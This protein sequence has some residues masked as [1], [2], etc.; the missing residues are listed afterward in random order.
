MKKLGI[1]VGLLLGM[2]TVASAGVTFTCPSNEQINKGEL[3][4]SKSMKIY[5]V[6]AN[7]LNFWSNRRNE[8][9]L[10][11]SGVVIEEEKTPMCLYKTPNGRTEFFYVS[12]TGEDSESVKKC[13]VDKPDLI[14]KAYA[15]KIG[16]NYPG[17]TLYASSN[18]EDL[19]VMCD[20]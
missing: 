12:T 14:D 19:K 16:T 20:D 10:T 15:G 13:K 17:Q 8:G 6:E 11:F 9:E 7:N 3:S 18:P 4:G 1:S 2:A 5:S